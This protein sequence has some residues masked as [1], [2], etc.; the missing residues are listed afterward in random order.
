MRLATGPLVELGKDYI[1]VKYGKPGEVFLGTVHR[2]DRPV[3]GVVVF[4]RTSKAL[5][6]MNELFRFPFPRN[7]KS[8]LGH[9]GSKTGKG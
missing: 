6:R 8:L 2:L 1:K 9:N 4:A 7:T 3:S 5:G